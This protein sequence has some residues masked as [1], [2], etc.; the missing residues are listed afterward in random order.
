MEI[1]INKDCEYYSEKQDNNC[2]VGV[3]VSDCECHKDKPS[4]KKPKGETP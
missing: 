1:C 3:D 4:P 2:L